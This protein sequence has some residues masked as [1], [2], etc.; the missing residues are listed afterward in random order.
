MVRDSNGRSIGD[1]GTAARLRRRADARR[2]EILR[3]AARIF[4]ERG[5]AGAGM[6]EIAEAADLSPANLYHYFRGKDELLYFCQSRSLDRMLAALAAARRSRQPA[7]ERLRHVLVAHALCLLDELE[8]SAAHLE[9]HALPPALRRRVVDKR[10]RYERGVRRLVA[11][12]AQRGELVA[13][14]PTVVTRAIL[15]ALNWTASWFRPDGPHAPEAV[16]TLVA[17]FLVRGV[18]AAP[19][20][21]AMGPRRARRALPL[22]A[23]L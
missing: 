20:R 10:D 6:R 8:G 22:E 4:R 16:A 3:A 17:D 2:V 1:R 13:P 14:D 21:A 11:E 5:F 12:G 7:P 18:D 15:G 23:T 9:V 19:A